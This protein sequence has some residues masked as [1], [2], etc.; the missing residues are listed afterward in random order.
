MINFLLNVTASLV[1]AGIVALVAV[2]CSRLI[3][4]A[5]TAAA[6]ALLGVEVKYVYS[7]GKEAEPAIREELARS[8][9]VRIFTGR[10]NQFQDTLYTPL[11]E[12]ATG[13]PKSVRILLPNVYSPA[14]GSDWINDREAE[15]A[16]I[17][18][19]FGAGQL[20][21]QIKTS[22]EHLQRY[23][24][25]N[26]IQLRLFDLP[27]LGRVIITDR[28]VFFTPYAVDKHGRDSRLIQFGEGEM[29]DS[30][31]RFFE[32]TW[33]D[34]VELPTEQCT[35]LANKALQPTAEDGGG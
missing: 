26:E 11:L 16:P 35:G 15:L 20:R 5:L 29:Y 17:D 9:E 21:N 34:S 1:A 30:F 23:L 13:R 28:S 6:A 4:R 24:K 7:K 33:K 3:R 14:R 18:K 19:A 8:R 10:G 31:S 27:H 32:L 12:P 25:P 2:S 22:I